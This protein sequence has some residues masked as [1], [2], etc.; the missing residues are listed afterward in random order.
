[1]IAVDTG[2]TFTD[3]L[4]AWPDG[5]LERVKVLSS[6]ALRGRVAGGGDGS[7]GRVEI[8]APWAAVSGLVRG[9]TLRRLD[10]GSEHRIVEHR[11][12]PPSLSLDPPLPDGVGAGAPF[13]VRSAEPAPLLA[14]R[15]LCGLAPEEPLPPLT[16]RLA[17]TRGTNA[18]L[19][20]KGTPPVLVV[21]RGFADLLEIG[22]QTRSDLFA[23]RIDRPSPLHEGTIE[24]D[25]RLDAHGAE[26]HPLDVGALRDAAAAH[27]AAG[28]DV[29]AVALLHA[30]L[31]DRH[32]RAAA[33][34]L[35]ELG[36]RHVAVSSELSRFVEILPRTQ[37]CVVDAYLAPVLED[38]LRRIEAALEPGGGRLLVMTSAGGLMGS[39][40]FHPKDGLLSGPAGGVAGAA[41]AGRAAGIERLLAF[42]MGGTSTDVSR[43]DGGFTYTFEHRVGDARLA[44]PA[45]EIETVAAGGGS[46]CWFDGVRLRVGPHSAGAE[47]GPACYGAGGPLTVT[48]VNLLLGRLTPQR[49]QIPVSVE[50]AE[51]ALEALREEMSRSGHE[52]PANEELAEGLLDLAN[53]V[54]SDAVRRTSVRSGHD[55]SE[56]ALVA[57]GGAGPQHACALADALGIDEVIVPR[58]AGVLSARGLA[59]AGLERFAEQ[60]I[61]EVLEPNNHARLGRALTELEHRARDAAVADGAS[62]DEVATLRR[63]ASARLVG[64]DAT[65]EIDVGTV[66]EIGER[67]AEEYRTVFGH[68]P[69]RRPIEL[70]ALRVVAGTKRHRAAASPEPDGRGG[71]VNTLAGEAK[72]SR[73]G[74]AERTLLR[75]RGAWHEAPVLDREAS[76]AGDRLEGPALIV[77]EHSA[78]A[79]EPGWTARADASGA[80]RLIR[81]EA[82]GEKEHEAAPGRLQ[83]RPEAVRVE[84]FSQRLT[85][86]AEEMGAVLERMAIS[87]NVKERRDFSCAVLD[88]GG[89]LVVNAPHIPVHL[90]SLGLCVRE[91]AERIDVGPGDTVVT[92]HPACGGS[93]L[94]DV[95]LVTPVHD[96]SGRHLAWVASRA[97]HAEIGGIA[98]GSMPPRA[99]RLIDEGVVIAP[100]HLVR[101]GEARW[102][103]LR[104]VLLGARHPTRSIQDNL[105]DLAA[106]LAAN[107]RGAQGLRLL[108]HEIG[109]GVLAELMAAL[110]DRAAA[111][112]GRALARLGRWE[113]A[114]ED[115]MDDGTRLAVR[116]GS[117]GR[118]LVVDFTGTATRHPGNLNATPAITRSALLYALR[119]MVDE[120]LPL[121]EG[122]LQPVDLVIPEGLLS[123]AF[124]DDP[125]DAPAVV[126]G[127]VETSQRLVNLLL[128]ALGLCA[129]SQGTMNNLVFGDG[130]RSYYETIAGGCGAGPDF[131]G[132]SAVHSHMT[133]TR[134][135]DAEILE[136]RYPVRL[137]RF[138]IRRGSGGA[139]RYPGGD[140]VVRSLLFL[141]PMELSLL[142]Q[143]R[144][145]GPAGMAGGGAGAPG[146]QWI[147]RADGSTV[148]LASV[149]GA[150]L[151]ASDVLNLETPGGGAWGASDS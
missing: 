3:A 148:E 43:F 117:D 18:L 29:A 76:R 79:L 86:I 120:P 21:N 84:L 59:A 5:S 129:A 50:A 30:D 62:K 90:G 1:M 102:E 119:L 25:A 93:H 150:K 80:L 95:T 16:L 8:D 77:D 104:S 11:G 48:D 147:Q 73:R 100:M 110:A 92:N 67:F 89:R 74:E 99:M 66:P 26:I 32:E 149:D 36:F 111:A 128:R 116:L 137:D 151:E 103:A 85:G 51:L 97:H 135:T 98:P 42:D 34:T 37:T 6:S 56:H 112:L 138:A 124:P 47:P 145:E 142:T 44:T 132:A 61:L 107:H 131:A 144:T 19:E 33:D 87:T 115:R 69:P 96:E 139:G 46:V 105:A 55:P 27:R 64:Q 14:A 17:T 20:R 136:R 35:R 122:L 127:N 146:R 133:N 54:M 13:E 106:A 2:G 121:N 38:Y 88:P 140:G 58:D 53:Q 118:R 108:A 134:I 83:E 72:D 65:L 22:D 82:G 24:V 114:A 41:D 4:A 143:H 40:S 12:D 70:V 28:R 101:G 71:R 57:F 78:T 109:A 39:G 81:A 45:L 10:V 141:A 123:P 91:I 94:P 49:F 15:W 9:L 23:L 63:I 31:D 130:E 75:A 126:G 113:R 125:A 60:Q 7:S 52:T 68:E